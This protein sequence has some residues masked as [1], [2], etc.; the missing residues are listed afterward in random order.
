[1]QVEPVEL[2][3]RTGRDFVVYGDDGL[4]RFAARLWD[5]DTTLHVTWTDNLPRTAIRV[6]EVQQLVGGTEAFDT[7]KGQA[8]DHFRDLLV[9]GDIEPAKMEDLMHRSLGNNWR[10]TIDARPGS[11]PPTFDITFTRTEG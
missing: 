6:R 1:M 10:L 5:N 8:S 7:I 2:F 9:T 4:E 11:I 3:G